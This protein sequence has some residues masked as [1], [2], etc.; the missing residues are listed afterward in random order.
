ML[1]VVAREKA[2]DFEHLLAVIANTVHDFVEIRLVD[3]VVALDDSLDLIASVL[4]EHV[5]EMR[6]RLVCIR[7]AIENVVSYR[8]QNFASVVSGINQLVDIAF[9]V[10]DKYMPS[11]KTVVVDCLEGVGVSKYDIE[12]IVADAL[13]SV[14]RNNRCRF[15]P[16]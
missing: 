15:L 11:R 6:R 9:G 12:I 8:R 13:L 14:R 2:A 1:L 4:C 3:F 7:A 16:A 5:G 10:E